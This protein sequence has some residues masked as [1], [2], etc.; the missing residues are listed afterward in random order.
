MEHMES[1][2][3][4]N[5]CNQGVC[6]IQEETML[7]FHVQRQKIL[8]TVRSWW[9]CINRCHPNPFIVV[10]QRGLPLISLILFGEA[11]ASKDNIIALDIIL[12][13]QPDSITFALTLNS[14]HAS[15][16]NDSLL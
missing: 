12:L 5:K 4:D 11:I 2:Q 3:S 7:V 9:P 14:P 16:R 15:V 6:E 10:F 8:Q 1:D 13:Q